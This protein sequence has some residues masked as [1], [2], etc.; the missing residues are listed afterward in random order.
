[1]AAGMAL[2]EALAA[3]S[4]VALEPLMKVEI[5]VPDEFLGAAIS[6]LGTCGGKVDDL[7]EQL[8]FTYLFI[9]HD[10]SVVMHISDR[11]GV[12]YLGKIVELGSCEDIFLRPAHPYTK[13]LLSA[14]PVPD[15]KISRQREHKVT[16]FDDTPAG[17]KNGGCS[18]CALCSY[19][20]A[21]CAKA[22]SENREIATGHFCACHLA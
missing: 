21:E 9:S 3:A 18:Y 15:P 12:M 14:I 17:I 1:M 6:L 20:T 7:Q 5:S 22:A 10:L 13:A 4:P 16:S 2:R 8:G 11:I 19:A